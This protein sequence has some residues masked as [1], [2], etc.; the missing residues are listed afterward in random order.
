MNN[1][2]I[3]LTSISSFLGLFITIQTLIDTRK[4]YYQ[5]YIKKKRHGKN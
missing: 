1:L 4:K 5:D 3:I 2:I